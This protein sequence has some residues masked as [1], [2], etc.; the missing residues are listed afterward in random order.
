MLAEP[1]EAPQIRKWFSWAQVPLAPPRLRAAAHIVAHVDALVTGILRR[2]CGLSPPE[3]PI[4]TAEIGNTP[5]RLTVL[6]S[7]LACPL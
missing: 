3:T 6:N 2:P 4:C 7:W 5:R 1:R